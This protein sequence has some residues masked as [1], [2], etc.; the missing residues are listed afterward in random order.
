MNLPQFSDDQLNQ[1]EQI[2]GSAAVKYIRA[3]ETTEQAASIY[4]AAQRAAP[5]LQLVAGEFATA[6]QLPTPHPFVEEVIDAIASA[7]VPPGA[8]QTA[9][10]RLVHAGVV[11]LSAVFD[12]PPVTDAT[13]AGPQPDDGVGGEVIPFPTAAADTTA[14]G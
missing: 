4:A 8:A 9:V 12:P 5:V 11:K 2:A 13:T 3:A 1:I 6:D 14:N 10:D 7:F